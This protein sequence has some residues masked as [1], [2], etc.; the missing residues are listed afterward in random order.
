MERKVPFADLRITDDKER[1]ELLEAIDTVF[2]HGRIVLGPEV[3]KFESKI[4]DFCGRKYA[5][6]VNSG[7]DALFLG[8][9]SLGIGPGDEVIT[10]SLSWVSGIAT[11]NPIALTGAKPIFA[12][13]C[14]DLNIDPKSVERLIT[15]RTK[16][17]LPIHYTGRICKIHELMKIAEEHNLL[18]VEDASQA[19]SASTKG[20]KAG[21]FGDISCLSMNPMK[22]LAACGEAGVVMTDDKAVYDRLI[23]LRY[24]GV[25]KKEKHIEV[26]LNSRIDT[27]QAAILLNRLK[28]ADKIVQKRREIASWYN[29]NL[30][31]LVK[32]PVEP[33][34][35]K[36]VYYTY[37]ILA[38][39]R[40]ELK[41]F[42]KAKGIETKIQHLYLMP[43]QQFNK[44]NTIE[45][46]KNAE[47]LIKQILSLP[48][49]EKLKFEDMKYVV[50]CIKEF[51]NE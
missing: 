5:M 13:I 2:K 30:K 35:E 4:A 9:K 27:L 16:A 25:I 11:A 42:L 31:G 19:F 28:N 23:S 33:K 37:T 41:D 20:R 1:K 43:Y 3:G 15:P 7:T 18:L 40:D 38:Q 6:G 51:Y 14:D 8:L 39:R 12:D 29:D 50:N 22:I 46:P 45:R 17:I 48:T 21:S 47:K 26:T 49:T 32:V 10:T 24:N 36:H 44:E 34:K